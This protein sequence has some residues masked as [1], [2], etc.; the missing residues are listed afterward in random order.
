MATNNFLEFNS[1]KLNMQN[2]S[3]YAAES[4]RTN[5][6]IG[7]IA[8]SKMHNKLFRQLSVMVSAIGEA[9]KN[10]GHDASDSDMQALAN[11][12]PES[13]AMRPYVD[14]QLASSAN[15]HTENM[16]EHSFINNL[17]LFFAYKAIGDGTNHPLSE[18]YSTLADAQKKYPTAIALTEYIDQLAIQTYINDVSNAGGGVVYIPKG[19]YNY[20]KLVIAR[21]NVIIHGE[22]QEVSILQC[23][24]G[25]L[26]SYK[27]SI[28]F[29]KENN[30]PI[31]NIGIDN[32]KIK[33]ANGNN[34]VLLEFNCPYLL[35]IHNLN[36]DGIGANVTCLKI[37][38]PNQVRIDKFSFIAYS[39]HGI[40]AVPLTN[41]GTGASTD[42]YISNG[43]LDSGDITKGIGLLLDGTGIDYLTAVNCSN[44][45]VFRNQ[46]PLMCN[47]IHYSKFLNCYFDTSTFFSKTQG[48]CTDILF[49]GCWFATSNSSGLSIEE[50]SNL[51]ELSGCTIFNNRLHGINII[52]ASK[53]ISI[54]HCK[55]IDN[56]Q[57]NTVGGQ[58]VNIQGGISK[59][60]ISHNTI[61]NNVLNNG[62]QQNMVAVLTGNSDYYIITNNRGGTVFDGG[63]GVNKNVSN[64]FVA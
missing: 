51:I 13:F 26:T 16:L 46:Y 57:S 12:I 52:G 37:I 24:S 62:H 64:N 33:N 2:D 50:T 47:S 56:N 29:G 27:N 31:K 45:E 17:K 54:H 25:D 5:G 18:K 34:G 23:V 40:W 60:D 3:E 55:I 9:I 6:V 59:F 8:K 1:N 22:G 39:A 4:Q 15:Q 42:L 38:N 35:D 43:H 44:L 30:T 32:L 21:D 20:S 14:A 19:T 49:Q 58:G 36:I 10:T 11:A 53:N 41:G 7:G 28:I 61:A 48:Y 63:T